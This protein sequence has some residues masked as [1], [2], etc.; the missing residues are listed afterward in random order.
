[1]VIDSSNW[2]IFKAPII[3]DNWHYGGGYGYPKLINPSAD[4]IIFVQTLEELQSAVE[5]PNA[6]VYLEDDVAIDITDATL[7]I[8]S[9]V[10][11]AGA[12]FCRFL[13]SGIL[14]CD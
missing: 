14:S 11:L 9:G 6:T 7:C 4:G 1:M 5:T 13:N 12:E 2:C 10:T 8:A 3:E